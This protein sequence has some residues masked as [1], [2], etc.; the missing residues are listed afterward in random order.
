M[1]YRGHVR[2]VNQIEHGFRSYSHTFELLSD[3]IYHYK[4]ENDP[5]MDVNTES[6]EWEFET[7]Q[8]EKLVNYFNNLFI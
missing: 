3:L 8:W 7:E 2:T 5:D 1:G 4:E 6:E